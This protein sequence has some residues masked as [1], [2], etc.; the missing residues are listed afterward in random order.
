MMFLL[1]PR[2]NTNTLLIVSDIQNSL[3]LLWI[4]FLSLRRIYIILLI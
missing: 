1:D 4:D 3:E 2:K